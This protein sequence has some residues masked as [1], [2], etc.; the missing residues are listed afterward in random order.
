MCSKRNVLQN[1]LQLCSNCA[2]VSSVYAYHTHAEC[3]WA[4]YSGHTHACCTAFK[5]TAV[6]ARASHEQ[7][8][9]RRF[10]RPSGLRHARFGTESRSALALAQLSMALHCHR[11]RSTAATRGRSPALVA[12]ASL[13]GL[14]NL[15]ASPHPAACSQVPALPWQL[16]MQLWPYFLRGMACERAYLLLLLLLLLLLDLI[17]ISLSFLRLS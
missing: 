5:G 14:P 1:V 11:S 15:D 7:H 17:L 4:L 2:P 9:H 3:D 13:E 8:E 12:A 6:Q 16:Q 10:S